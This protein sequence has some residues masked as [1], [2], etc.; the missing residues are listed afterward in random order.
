[1]IHSYYEFSL[2]ICMLTNSLN[3]DSTHVLKMTAKFSGVRKESNKEKTCILHL[4]FLFISEKSGL[5]QNTPCRFSL[6]F[7]GHNSITRLYL[8]QVLVWNLNHNHRFN[9][10]KLA[11]G[12]Y[13]LKFMS[14]SLAYGCPIPVQ[15]WDSLNKKNEKWLSDLPYLT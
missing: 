6:M 9:W 14:F 15:N 8:F 5:F 11:I 10:V 7:W 2:L 3:A 1:M 12:M 4:I 13:I